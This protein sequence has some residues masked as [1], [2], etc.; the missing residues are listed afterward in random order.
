MKAAGAPLLPDPG[1]RDIPPLGKILG[2]EQGGRGR[3]R[4]GSQSR[5]DIGK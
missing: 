2:R 3:I 4:R 5:Y 1:F